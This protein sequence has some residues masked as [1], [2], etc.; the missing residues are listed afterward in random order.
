MAKIAMLGTGFIGEFYTMALH[1]QRNP[2]RVIS[3][4]SRSEE[5]GK[6][7]AQKWKIPKWTTSM[8]EAVNDPEIDAVIISLPNHLHLEAVQ[9][10]PEPVKPYYAPNPWAV[11][12]PKPKLC[13]KR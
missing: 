10:L 9:I 12:L 3:V 4:Y 11:R 13:W 6:K 2:D 8:E 5:N 1:G 7:F